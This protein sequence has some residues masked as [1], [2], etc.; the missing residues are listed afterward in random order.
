MAPVRC[1]P[2]LARVRST[3]CLK[4]RVDV[5]CPDRHTCGVSGV[6]GARANDVG[7]AFRSFCC[8]LCLQ[9]V[10]RIPCRSTAPS[11]RN[12]HTR[13]TCIF[14]NNPDD[15]V[16]VETTCESLVFRLCSGHLAIERAQATRYVTV[17]HNLDALARNP[18]SR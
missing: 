3:S 4:S 1:F 14:G 11:A 18:G 6:N 15:L 17:K 7:Q 8:L 16:M 5:L 13:F 2:R 12:S 9:P 10:P